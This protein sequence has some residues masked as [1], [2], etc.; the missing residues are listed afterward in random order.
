M[1]EI[2]IDGVTYVPASS[3]KK[4]FRY[5]ADYIGQ[6][7]RAK[8]VDARLVGRSW[9]VNPLSLKNHK[10]NKVKKNKKEDNK[11]A[12]IT[13]NIKISRTD[14][15][16]KIIH[17]SL[18]TPQIEKKN[19]VSRMAW[20][21]ANYESDEQDLLPSLDKQT[22][23]EEPQKISVFLAD[24]EK[25]SIKNKEKVTILEP[26]PMPEVTLRGKL[27]IASLDEAF[28]IEEVELE[29]TAPEAYFEPNTD[30]FESNPPQNKAD[31]ARDEAPEPEIPVSAEAILR[32]AESRISLIPK[33][34][35]M[36][37][38]PEPELEVELVST[39]ITRSEVIFFVT[40]G[41]F[42]LSCV[43]LFFGEIITV[44][45]A[46]AYQNS[47]NFSTQSFT[48]LLSYFGQ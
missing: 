14:E 33:K 25:I 17:N 42:V 31:H 21:P 30:D 40:T 35:K 11:D 13:Y 4:E 18:I 20:K 37:S 36:I 7:C 16:P 48:A 5:T 43:F 19:F 27:S 47:L 1:K 10:L 34:H 3:L 8:K 22:V 12:D 2:S 41:T 26:E 38:R 39:T 29:Q 23:D 6:L 24:S 28:D 45:N 46:D 15:T 44:A 9:Y 32:A